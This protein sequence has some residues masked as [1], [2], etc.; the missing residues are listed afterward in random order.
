MRY[1]TFKK[2]TKEGKEEWRFNKINKEPKYGI[3]L[4]PIS[5]SFL[6]MNSIFISSIAV[7]Q[8]LTYNNG[9]YEYLLGDLVPAI[10]VLGTFGF[11]AVAILITILGHLIYDS[12]KNWKLVKEKSNEK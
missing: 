12:Y 1:K 3:M 7:F 10:R 8:L 4:G 2:L 6:L 5:F 11:F 9:E